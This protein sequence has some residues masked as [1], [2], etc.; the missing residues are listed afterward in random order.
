MRLRAWVSDRSCSQANKIARRKIECLAIA[1]EKFHFAL[2][3]LTGA[4]RSG[5]D[6]RML[7]LT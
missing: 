1:E 3:A 2:H 6:L 5:N 7:S 4:A